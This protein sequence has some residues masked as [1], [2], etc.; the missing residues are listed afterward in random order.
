MK[1]NLPVI[2]AL[3][4]VIGANSLSAMAESD[5]STLAPVTNFFSDYNKNDIAKASTLFLEELSVTDAF[6]PFYWQGRDA[7]KNWM[8]DLR[9]F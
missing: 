1:R 4:P 3:A 6:L 9:N 7:F 8:A 2:F 5:A